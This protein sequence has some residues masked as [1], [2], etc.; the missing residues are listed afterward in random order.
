MPGLAARLGPVSLG[1]R[2]VLLEPLAPHHRDDLLRA[3]SDPRVWTHLKSYPKTANEMEH[4]ISDQLVQEAEGRTCPFIV[5]WKA[6]GEVIGTTRLADIVPAHHRAAIS[7]TWF[8]PEYWG[9]PAN[10]EA[11]YL[12][13]RHAFETWGAVRIQITTDERNERSQHAI[14]KIGFVYEG[15]LRN[16]YVRRD[17]S[18]RGSLMYSV[19]A[20]EWPAVRAGLEARLERFGS[21]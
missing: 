4:W 18:Y 5:R 15:F 9:G 16:H 17:G 2:F 21:Q 11:K 12:L 14:L 1:G 10:P 8:A 7:G 20:S 6:S 13:L 19:I 3:G